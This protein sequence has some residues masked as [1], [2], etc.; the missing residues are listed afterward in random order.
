M[1]MGVIFQLFSAADLQ[2]L[3][4]LSPEKLNEL[5]AL[6]QAERTPSPEVRAK[7]KPRADEVFLQLVPSFPGPLPL[8]SSPTTSPPL[9]GQLFSQQDL[10]QL[11]PDQL[12]IL[13]WAIRCELDNSP[14][15]LEVI[16]QKVLTW[17]AEQGPQGLVSPPPPPAPDAVYSPFSKEYKI[18][19]ALD[20]PDDL[21]L[22]ERDW[23]WG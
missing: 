9:A 16:M 12:R 4:A 19:R 6:I 13:E 15:V 2:K 1:T 14:Y 21:I 7:L 17:L 3:A 8:P 5:Q 11:T 22:V 10:N 18:V 23:P 20:P